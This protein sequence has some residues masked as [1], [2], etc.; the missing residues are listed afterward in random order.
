MTIYGV[1]RYL[2]PVQR[3]T[4]GGYQ[5]IWEVAS[6]TRSTIFTDPAYLYSAANVDPAFS[7]DYPSW[8]D[9]LSDDVFDKTGVTLT[10]SWG[11]P[12]GY[13]APDGLAFDADDA[14]FGINIGTSGAF[15]RSI[16]GYQGGTG[17][18][19]A[20]PG[21]PVVAPRSGIG[22]WLARTIIGYEARDKKSI[23]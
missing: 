21:T 17:V 1:D 6:V 8:L 13:D 12:A 3:E 5:V 20:T 19:Y 9:I 22:H 2:Y 15:V 11:T 7:N 4:G 23:S 18:V 16:L 10:W 14:T